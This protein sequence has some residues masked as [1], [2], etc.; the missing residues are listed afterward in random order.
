ML[1]IN[2]FVGYRKAMNQFKDTEFSTK[3]RQREGNM[4][5][6]ATYQGASGK[7]LTKNERETALRHKVTQQLEVPMLTVGR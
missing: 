7:I 2:D 4:F 3:T 5:R 1:K 6:N